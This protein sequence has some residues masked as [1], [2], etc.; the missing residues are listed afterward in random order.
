MTRTGRGSTRYGRPTAQPTGDYEPPPA[1]QRQAGGGVTVAF[2]GD[3]DRRHEFAF[4]RLPLPGWHELLAS[5]FAE[6]VGPEGTL[7]TLTSARNAWMAL[8]RLMRFLHGQRPSPPSTPDGLTLADIKA[9]YWHR[10]AGNVCLGHADLRDVRGILLAGQIGHLL[11]TG[12]VDFL[13]QRLPGRNHLGGEPGY[14]NGELTRLVSAARADVAA[15]RDRI[16]A[17]ED[18]VARYKQDPDAV[19]AAD[20]ELAA[21]LAIIADTGAVPDM[22][23]WGAVMLPKRINLA[24]HLF[25]TFR[26]LAPLM[27]LLAAVT[28]RNGETLKELPA[29]HS[30]LDGRAV[31]LE[32]IK[33]RRGPRKW[34]EKVTWEIGPPSRELH[35]PGG[36]YLLLLTLT[37][38]SRAVCGSPHLFCVWGN[39]HRDGERGTPEHSAVFSATL[40]GRDL[41]LSKWAAERH[42][43]VLADPAPTPARRE[44]DEPAAEP[45]PVALKV[46]FN[47]IKTSVDIRRTKQLGGHLPSAA[48][49]NTMP[50]L[51]NSY[52]RSDPTMLDW[53]H[54]VMADAVSEAERAALD[55][56]ERALTAAG[57]ALLVV[58]GPTEDDRLE[59]AGLNWLAERA[60]PDESAPTLAALTAD[61]LLGYQ[62]FLVKT[63]PKSHNA[64][65]FARVAVRYFWRWRSHLTIDWLSIDPLHVE[66]WAEPQAPRH[67]R[68]NTTDRVPEQVLGPLVAWSL[69]F[70]DL[71]SPDILAADQEWRA[72]RDPNRLQGTGDPGAARSV[73]AAFLDDHVARNKPLPG[74][75]GVVNVYFV[76]T[77]L[78]IAR[79]SIERN[80]ELVDAAVDVVGVSSHTTFDTPISVE[81]DGRAW[82]DGFATNH[83]DPDSVARMARHLQVACYV[84]IAYLSGMR[85]SEVKHLRRGSVRIERDADGI[86]YRWKVNSLAF[87][88]ENDPRGVPATW[89]VGEPVTRAIDVL[90][91]LHPPEVDHLF[92]RLGHGPGSKPSSATTALTNTSTNIQ[93][94]ILVTWINTFCARHD[95]VDVIPDVKGQVW[96]LHT[97]Q[98]R[99][100]LAWFI[101]RQPGGAIAGAVQYRHHGTQMFEGYA[102]TSEA[103]FRAE[104]ESEQAL[105]RGEH[106]MT[107]IDAHEHHHLGGP[108]ATEAAPRLDE[109]GDQAL[110]QG[111]VVLD[112][113]RLLRIMKKND[114][115]VYPGEYITCV[116]D[117]TKALCERA[118]RG[119]SEGL[120]DHGGCQPFACRNVALTSENTAA[121]HKEIRRLDARLATSPPLPPLLHHRVLS[122]RNEIDVFLI[123]NALP[124]EP[125]ASS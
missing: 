121:L 72:F 61:D 124:D 68:E 53:A 10:A 11:D 60:G 98:F 32:V 39:R 108:A 42:D 105:A 4:G 94:N 111:K 84:V 66:G 30:V 73:L 71:F 5:A 82:I 47:R 25:L 75:N 51:F 77:K 54:E 92:A 91:A 62:R 59:Q 63:L 28:G 116:H 125:H 41:A 19:A 101:A 29:A 46:S 38:R 58:A 70:V 40:H 12:V 55:A 80:Q 109:L 74:R 34:F 43:P 81:L 2:H 3:D 16:K 114:P 9:F 86:A 123:R 83:N 48:R 14:S 7:R 76:A 65:S 23:G 22:L 113:H 119:R 87:K 26:D 24:S 20:R 57:G 31:E 35:T 50:V 15:I 95:R 103:G 102:G 90:E 36:V 21:A 52:L 99:R 17:G 13:Q 78:G 85:D 88:G 64:R 44:G 100:T 27:V 6:R 97:R 112:R 89:V 122:R 106:L 107:M 120:P 110:Y 104:V 117:H 79:H 115:G 96:H 67:A 18:L 118:K 45:D 37:A 49:S 69:R 8:G 1:V 33:R 93:L 56:H